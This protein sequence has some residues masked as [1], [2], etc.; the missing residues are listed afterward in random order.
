[1]I[2]ILVSGA[3]GNLEG[4]EGNEMTQRR[5]FALGVSALSMLCS[6]GI[7][8]AG[9]AEGGE[10][11]TGTGIIPCVPE[12]EI[13]GDQFDN[14]CDGSI[15]ED[16]ECVPGEMASC[17]SGPEGTLGKGTC[18]EGTKTCTTE[19]KWSTCK[20]EV[21][22]ADTDSCD[23][24]DNDCNGMTD[25]GCECTPP[26][27][28]TTRTCY[29]GPDG[30]EGV[31]DCAPGTQSCQ[32]DGTWGTD[33]NNQVLPIDEACDGADN[34]CNGLIDDMGTTSCG[35]GAC[36]VTV[37]KCENGQA[38]QCKS[39]P[40][41]QE[42]CD[43]IDN[44]CDQLV[45]ES[46]PNNGKPCNTG[47][48]GI[49]AAG[50]LSCQGGVMVCVA[51]KQP[52]SQEIC[53]GLDDDCKG[54]VDDNIPGTGG[55][56][57]TGLPG[58]CSPGTISCQNN[59]I[60]CFP[61]IPPSQEI[62]DGIDNDCDDFT[63][64]NNPGGGGACDTGQLGVC[65]PGILNCINGAIECTPNAQSSVEVCNGIDDDCDG[66]VDDGNPGGGAS[67]TT[68]QLGVC[69]NGIKNCVNGVVECTP[70][71]A[72]STEV[73][74]GKDDDCDGSV[75]ENNPGGGAACQTG[76]P[77][78][79]ADGTETCQGGALICKQNVAAGPEICNNGLDDNC[80]GLPDAAPV[81]YFFETFANNNAGW[82]LGTQWAIGPA[83]VSSG[84]N[85]GNPDPSTDHTSAT[86]DNGVAGVVLGGNASTAVHS[87]YYLVSPVIDLSAAPGPVYLAY[88]RWLNS[89]Y[90]PYM[91]NTVD[92]YNGTAWVTIWTS[93]GFPGVTDNTWSKQFHTVTNHKNAAF[94]VR[95]GFSVSSGAYT[96]SQWNVDD[97]QLTNVQC[98]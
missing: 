28:E 93:G 29:T 11:G 74:N 34:D 40:P 37:V 6:A 87:A 45:D 84:H 70:N 2:S 3:F 30:T 65:Q 79:C 17:Y 52:A 77:G 9:C 62:C 75:D 12:P 59:T 83:A 20:N 86:A 35:I 16:C 68:G 43:M 21:L 42:I 47:N 14:D 76:I 46:D 8:F 94:Q 97:V 71:Q 96:V 50:T 90:A 32:S 4:L 67:C 88:W 18:A 24:L 72:A 63:D 57:T 27:P 36:K 23:G 51:S 64:E 56:C 19:G 44:D 91:V 78:V 22:P 98:N 49:C 89:D 61:N 38:K 60:D 92:V 58:I 85:Y 73:C 54:G 95:F 41:S 15:D 7:L 13:C 66:V 1:M 33:C 10:T 81:D 82:T 25:P 5:A 80:D 26:V 53:N 55:A 69:G 39:L 48:P 31:G